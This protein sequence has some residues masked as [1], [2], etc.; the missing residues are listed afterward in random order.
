MQNK[1][2]QQQVKALQEGSPQEPAAEPAEKEPKKRKRR[3]NRRFRNPESMD[4][5]AVTRQDAHAIARKLF[6]KIIAYCEEKERLLDELKNK[7][8]SPERREH[9]KAEL[10]QHLRTFDQVWYQKCVSDLQDINKALSDTAMQYSLPTNFL[11]EATAENWRNHLQRNEALLISLDL[12][13]KVGQTLEVIGDDEDEENEE[14]DEDEE[15]AAAPMDD[16]G[17]PLSSDVVPSA[18]ASGAKGD[19]ST[20]ICIVCSTGPKKDPSAGGMDGL[21][22]QCTSC[23]N[24]VHLS[25][26][27]KCSHCHETLCKTCL[28]KHLEGTAQLDQAFLQTLAGTL[29]LGSCRRVSRMMGR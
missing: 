12:Q 14:Q 21:R 11:N 28:T 10:T 27:G 7:D 23:D 17:S 29:C 16:K 6:N 2:L 20:R 18:G 13:G 15:N 19:T 1:E 25:C 24:Y 4:K 26:Q 22:T 5:R 8:I 3:S 9:L